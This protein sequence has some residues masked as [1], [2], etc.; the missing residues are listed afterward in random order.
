M[1][2]AVC[3]RNDL[4]Y[5]IGLHKGEDADFYLHRGFAVVG[6]EANPIL[7]ANA[8]RRFQ[9]QL[10]S[11]ELTLVE[12]AIAPRSANDKVVFYTNGDLTA[13]GTIEAKWAF[14]NETLGFP[15]N[16]I[17][18]SRID[19]GQVFRSFGIPFYLKIDVEG[20]DRL[21]VEELKAFRDRPQYLSLESEKEDFDKLKEEMNLLAS[22]G[23]EKFKIVQQQSIPS[24]S[25]RTRARNG[26]TFEYVF[27]PDSSGPFGEDL[28]GPWLTYDEAIALYK[29]IF[30][31]YRY[32][33]D[34]GLFKKMP[35]S[36]QRLIRV[37]YRL[38][39][40]YRGPLPG[41]F[42]THASL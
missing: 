6:V 3:M 8:R 29:I 30:L 17:E 9:N 16:R 25:V 35:K 41:W 4:I 37:L 27:E 14:R 1:G 2:T 42:D 19:I 26:G 36:V 13:W 32:F 20:V 31:R 5:D 39:S 11:G 15:S 28:P 40:G 12:G 34:H 21:V 38:A 18:V 23:Y 7:A 22:L 24:T 33:G 10:S